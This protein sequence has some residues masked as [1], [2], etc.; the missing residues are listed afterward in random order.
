MQS[1]NILKA[2]VVFMFSLYGAAFLED[3][4]YSFDLTCAEYTE[5][6]EMGIFEDCVGL[7]EEDI[8][9]EPIPILTAGISFFRV[10]ACSACVLKLKKLM[11]N[12]LVF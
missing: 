8:V 5:K 12:P 10:P 9:V 1:V 7:Q 11:A 4:N 6:G 3:V 2:S